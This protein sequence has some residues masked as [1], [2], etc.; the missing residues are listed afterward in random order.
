MCEDDM[1]DEMKNELLKILGENQLL[2][3]FLPHVA[4]GK[5]SLNL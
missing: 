1:S 5:N 2:E 3:N 4:A